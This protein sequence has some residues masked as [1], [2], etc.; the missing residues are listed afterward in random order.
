MSYA[1][2]VLNYKEE[3][4]HRRNSFGLLPQ[5][6]KYSKKVEAVNWQILSLVMILNKPTINESKNNEE[7]KDF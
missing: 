5:G 7:K 2:A 3:K 1:H 6:Y 4:E